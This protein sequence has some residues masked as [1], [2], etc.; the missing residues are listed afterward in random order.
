M[1]LQDKPFK[2]SLQ[3]LVRTYL[4]IRKRSIEPDACSLEADGEDPRILGS[5]HPGR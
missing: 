4:D 5:L 1:M 3:L 2:I